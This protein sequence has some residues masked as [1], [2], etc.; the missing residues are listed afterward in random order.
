MAFLDN[1]GL[2]HLISKFLSKITSHA[3]DTT[4]H[5]TSTERTN[6]NAAKTHASSAHAP[7]N[8]EKNQNAF[9]NVTVGSTTI[10][11]DTTTDTL[12]LVAGSN[13]TITPDATNDKITIGVPAASGSVAGATIVYPAASCT[14]FSSDSRESPVSITSSQNSGSLSSFF[15]CGGVDATTPLIS[16]LP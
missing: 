8:A 3:G 14:T 12:T 6:W 11:A 9:S 5:I 10:A 13:V 15:R 16:F 7:S 4:A 2:E 1:T